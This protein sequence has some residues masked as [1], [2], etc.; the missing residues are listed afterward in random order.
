[1]NQ[2]SPR[3]LQKLIL[4]KKLEKPVI[5]YKG[6]IKSYFSE[7]WVKFSKNLSSINYEKSVPFQLPFKIMNRLIF[8]LK[9]FKIS[10]RCT[11]QKKRFY[12]LK[13]SRI[14][15][16]GGKLFSPVWAMC[17]RNH[18]QYLRPWDKISDMLMGFRGQSRELTL[19][20]PG[21]TFLRYSEL[22]EKVKDALLKLLNGAR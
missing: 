7:M 17:L 18:S 2:R 21:M 15:P 16:V 4:W 11:N 14:V 3:L 22:Y 9:H 19:R 8:H 10:N 20:L 13:I 12:Y 6:N 5:L 1:M